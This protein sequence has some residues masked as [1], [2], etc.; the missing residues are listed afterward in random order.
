M[1]KPT[2]LKDMVLRKLDRKDP[3][4]AEAMYD[5]L[6][7]DDLIDLIAG[8]VFTDFGFR[9]GEAVF[10]VPDDFEDMG[11]LNQYNR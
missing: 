2:K 8:T 7:N 1:V 9:H 3:I 5:N 6:S 10:T 11:E 4:K